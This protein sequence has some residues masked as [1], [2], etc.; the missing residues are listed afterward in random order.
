MDWELMDKLGTAVGAGL[1]GWFSG[2]ACWSGRDSAGGPASGTEFRQDVSTRISHTH[3]LTGDDE[4]SAGR[5]SSVS[6]GTARG[7]SL[8]SLWRRSTS[9]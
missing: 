3:T 8:W 4:V 7:P 2:D 9:G 6:S 5:R 1:M